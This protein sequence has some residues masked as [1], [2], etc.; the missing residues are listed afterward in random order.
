M[1]MRKL[2]S[3]IKKGQES[4]VWAV[5][6]VDHE[7]T[8]SSTITKES[9]KGNKRVKAK[10]PQ[11]V[12]VTNQDAVTIANAA[13][14]WLNSCEHERLARETLRFYRSIVQ[15]SINPFI[16]YLGLIEFSALEV[17]QFHKTLASTPYPD[18]F[19]VARF[20]G[21]LRSR[22]A[23]NRAVMVLG[24]VFSDAMLNNDVAHNPVMALPMKYRRNA[25]AREQFGKRLQLGVH[26]PTNEEI[27]L[28]L[29]N[30][31]GWYATLIV[32]AIFSG[33]R[34]TELRGLRWSDVNLDGGYLEVRRQAD[35]FGQLSASKGL[36]GFRTVPLPRTVI[37]SLREWRGHCPASPFDLVFPSSGGAA[38]GNGKIRAS[39]ISAVRGAG[40]MVD[41]GRRDANGSPIL[42]PKYSSLNSFRHWYAFWCL[43]SVEDGGLGLPI[44]M[45]QERMGHSSVEM[46]MYVY[47]HLFSAGKG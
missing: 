4:K 28:I 23:V 19:P 31:R 16:G 2:R 45:V 20:R 36:A 15:H 32:T 40:L 5:D 44:K 34:A 24:A 14:R 27:R 1:T 3:K 39:L 30:V 10:D 12:N 17:I 18:D 33:L 25:S 46:T 29:A 9:E 43:Q 37:S 38:A 22:G 13:Q 41:S 26:I 6:Y 21:Q 8:S 47:G 11:V 7:H 42:K 35:R